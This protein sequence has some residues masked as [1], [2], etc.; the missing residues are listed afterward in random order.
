MR[1]ISSVIFANSKLISKDERSWTE[2]S[3][4]LWLYKPSVSKAIITKVDTNT[5][6]VHKMINDE[7]TFTKDYPNSSFDK[8]IEKFNK[9][10]QE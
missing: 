7:I 3:V 9:L 5:F 6:R 10:I 1:Q 8:A 4:Y 2:Y